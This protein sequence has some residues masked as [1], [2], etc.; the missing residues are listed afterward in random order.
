MDSLQAMLC[1]MTEQIVGALLD[2]PSTAKA[3]I[4]VCRQLSPSLVLLPFGASGSPCA[5]PHYHAWL[6]QAA[7]TVSWLL[8]V[9]WTASP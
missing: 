9:R 8:S 4:A 7:Q 5:A 1:N 2:T 6:Q 3:D